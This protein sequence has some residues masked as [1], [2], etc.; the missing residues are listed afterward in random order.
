M[1]RKETLFSEGEWFIVP[2]RSGAH[3]IGLVARADKR[4]ASFLGYY[5]PATEPGAY[6]MERLNRLTPSDAVLVSASGSF[7]FITKTWTVIGK[8]H[9]WSRERW[10]IPVFRRVDLAG[11]ERY[12]TYG[13]DNIL[14]PIPATDAVTTP[15]ISGSVVGDGLLD[16]A[17][18]E[19]ALWYKLRDRSGSK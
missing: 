2:L 12:E 16:A 18:V 11:R 17:A 1:G 13:D 8:S 5:F 7:G 19:D 6:D 4:G 15:T 3:A 10:P 14:L 9:A